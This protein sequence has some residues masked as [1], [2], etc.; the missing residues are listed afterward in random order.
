MQKRHL[1][2]LHSKKHTNDTPTA[3]V[4]AH[5]PQISLDFAYQRH[6]QGPAKLNELDI[7]TNHF[8]LLSVEISKPF[9]YGFSSQLGAE[10]DDSENWFAA[11]TPA[12]YHERYTPQGFLAACILLGRTRR[13]VVEVLCLG[14]KR[15]VAIRGTAVFP[16]LQRRTTSSPLVSISLSSHR[17][18]FQPQRSRF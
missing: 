1:I 2:S 9:T 10:E 12:L 5:F 16:P 14:A 18:G 13:K 4:G 7:L 3:Q 11:H 8:A 15:L 6:A 17:N